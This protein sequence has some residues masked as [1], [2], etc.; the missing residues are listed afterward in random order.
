MTTL[1]H[2][3]DSLCGVAKAMKILGGK[4]TILILKNLCSGKKRFGQLQRTL[5]GISPKTLSVRLKELEEEGLLTRT[6]FTEIPLHVEY[7]LTP[8]GTS[9]KKIIEQMRLWG[10]K[11]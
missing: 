3:S 6:V 1:T 11:A 10:E 8:K 7:A 2:H 9:L 5:P 4:W